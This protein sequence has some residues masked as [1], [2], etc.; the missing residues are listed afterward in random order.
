MS[1]NYYGNVDKKVPFWCYVFFRIERKL[2]IFMHLGL[3]TIDLHNYFIII[4]LYVGLIKKII[5]IYISILYLYCILIYAQG[6][7]NSRFV[8]GP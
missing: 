6:Q 1:I 3:V 4:R 7:T 8:M 5:Y 2:S